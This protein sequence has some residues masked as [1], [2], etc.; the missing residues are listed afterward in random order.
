MEEDSDNNSLFERT[1]NTNNHIMRS[2]SHTDKGYEM[3]GSA[4]GDSV[5]VSSL[6]QPDDDIESSNGKKAS[7]WLQQFLMQRSTSGNSNSEVDIHHDDGDDGD[8]SPDSDSYS[9]NQRMRIMQESL[10]TNKRLH[11]AEH[12]LRQEREFGQ[13]PEIE[14]QYDRLA[15]RV[16]EICP[17]PTPS[18]P[19]SHFPLISAH[20]RLPF[21]SSPNRIDNIYTLL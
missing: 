4:M 16:E 3:S 18:P 21:P 10:K 1:N 8:D 7:F 17:A 12:S 14:A 19:H 15:G 5:L 13:D 20:H 2:T 6:S 9:L 11:E